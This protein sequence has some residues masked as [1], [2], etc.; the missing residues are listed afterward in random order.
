MIPPWKEFDSPGFSESPRCQ[1]P[2]FVEKEGLENRQFTMVE[3]IW[4]TRCFHARFPA[5]SEAIVG[6]TEFEVRS[7]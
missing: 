7:S 4:K 1:N 3:A 2:A 6:E 5:D